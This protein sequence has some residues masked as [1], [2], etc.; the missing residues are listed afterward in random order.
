VSRGKRGA[1]TG[2][3]MAGQGGRQDAA[4]HLKGLVPRLGVPPYGCP[5]CWGVSGWGRRGR[6]EGPIGEGPPYKEKQRKEF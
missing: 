1:T 6:A 3:T 4:P 2:R 5:R